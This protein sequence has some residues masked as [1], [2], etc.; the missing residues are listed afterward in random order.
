MHQMPTADEKA[1]KE[2]RKKANLAKIKNKIMVQS[3][4]GGVGKSTVSVNLA[5]YYASKGY[6]TG[7]L[8]VDIHGPSMARMTGI[9]G[10]GVPMAGSTPSPIRASENLYVLSIASLMESVDDPIIWRGSMLNSVIN[11][12]L[13]DFDWPELDYLIIDNPPG[14][15]D[16]PLTVAQQIPGINGTVIVSTPQDVALL[17]ARK[18]IVFS[19]KMNIP[20][21]GLI[22]NMSY[23]TCPKC[24][25]RIEIFPKGG[26]EKAS[27]DFGVEILGE[28]PMDP[29]I[30]KS[31][32]EGRSYVDYHP[33]TLSAKIFAE[34]AEKIKEKIA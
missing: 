25:E 8:D 11:Q 19:Q 15:G 16:A 30:G 4:K 24:D 29:K 21:V 28:L 34:I 1:E 5:F 10:R 20:V 3:G 13:E 32:D 31:G 22:E 12:F 27:K 9:E 14:T 7:I 6:K 17:D 23:A 26:I 33:E 18:S 2:T